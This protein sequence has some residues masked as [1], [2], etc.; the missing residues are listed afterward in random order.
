MVGKVLVLDDLIKEDTLG[1]AIALQW[2]NWNMGRTFKIADW[3]ELRRYLYAT[4]TTH[5]TNQKL[6]WS[7]STTLPKLTQIRD[8]LY[9]NYIATM[10][11][12]RR[13]LNWEGLSA[14]DEDLMKTK[15]IKDYMMWAVSQPQFKSEVKKLVLDY[16]DYGNCFGTVEWIDQTVEGPDGI[17]LGFV[18]PR[19]VR[20]SPHDLVM[21]PTAPAFENSPKIY[22]TLMN[23]GEA[24][25][26]LERMSAT[27]TDRELAR[28]VFQYCLDVR[29][30]A[31]AYGSADITAVND[32]YMVDGFTSFRHY[33]GSD[34]VEL[35]TFCG[36][37][38]DREKQVF[39]KDHLIVVIDR[40]KV[41]IKRPYPY[42]L[43]EIPI[44][45]SG[46]RPRQDNL[47]AMGPL[48]NLVGLQYRL[49]HI[50]NMKSD[51]MDLVTYPPIMIRGSGAVSDFEW[52]PMER[53]YVDSDGDVDIKSPDV[54]AL[55]V[56]IEIQ[57]IMNT[58]EE[59]AGSPKEA[60][61]FRTPGEKTAYEVQRLENA[62]S[63]IFQ[64]KIAQFEEQIIEPLLNAMLV[65]AKEN[66]NDAT[67]RVIDDEYGVVG[68]SQ[69]T[70]QDLSANGRLKPVAARHFAEQAELIQNLSNYSQ[71]ALGQDAEIRQHFSS[72]QTAR[73]IED[74]LNL[75]DYGVVQPY[76]RISEQ[77]T[78]MKLQQVAQESV[79]VEAGTPSG[80][81]PD[82]YSEP[83]LQA[84][85]LGD[86]S[87]EGSMNSGPANTPR[88]PQIPNG[89]IT[90][91]PA[92]GNLG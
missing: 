10:F 81:T 31:A 6:P 41:A 23:I 20:I 44:F 3:Q 39:L 74:T 76:V 17:K 53:I 54:N 30:T 21:N 14:S 90:G 82:D 91:S 4:D 75:V 50:E 57:N 80:L 38:Y 29:N 87:A 16:I 13:W 24:K 73:L 22:R 37:I 26:M 2:I 72:V 15:K 66:L 62:A 46:W 86:L 79:A 43:A 40:H 56:N 85:D 64:N 55:Q 45:H 18:G 27:E 11:P 84:S 78:A 32:M 89:S 19:P 48:D 1:C 92:A 69:V 60:M 25:E 5:T 61:G 36:D 71:S 67:I 34:Y 65:L 59:M 28:E 9:S 83:G 88:N 7:N 33:L 58:M 8:N 35:L 51:L 63:R 12:K 47:W 77:A 49:D 42:P 68:F 70:R 52:G